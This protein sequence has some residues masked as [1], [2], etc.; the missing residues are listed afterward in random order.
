MCIYVY[1]YICTYTY[2]LKAFVRNYMLMLWVVG[3]GWVVYVVGADA[4]VWLD[5]GSGGSVARC[6]RLT[7]PLPGERTQSLPY[8]RKAQVAP[9]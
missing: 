9:S 6:C 1:I 3:G 2:I 7:F 5:H 8:L 4:D